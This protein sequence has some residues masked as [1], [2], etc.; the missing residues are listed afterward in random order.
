[1]GDFVAGCRHLLD[2]D[3][4]PVYRR[5]PFRQRRRIDWLALRA[6]LGSREFW[7]GAF[8][9]AVA[10]FVAHI[11]SWEFDLVGARRDVLRAIPILAWLPWLVMTRRRNIRALSCFRETP[12]RQR[13]PRAG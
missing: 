7:R 6:L 8:R 2:Y 10:T 12:H 3:N 13:E 4:I 5:L 9:V 1:M 11:L